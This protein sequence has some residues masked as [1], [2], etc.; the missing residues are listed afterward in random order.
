MSAKEIS[1]R[2]SDLSK[3]V[4]PDRVRKEVYTDAEIFEREMERIHETVWIY[5][6]HESQVPKAGDYCTVQIGRKPMIMERGKDRR[7]KVLYNRCPHS[8]NM[9]VDDRNG[10]T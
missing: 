1:M 7:E 10:N 5:C 3:Y 2:H 9:I 8:C 4:E 6:G